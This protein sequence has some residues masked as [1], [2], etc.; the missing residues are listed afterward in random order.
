MHNV[1][2]AVKMPTLTHILTDIHGLFCGLNDTG[3]KQTGLRGRW[4]DGAV[5]VSCDQ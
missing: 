4:G 5:V 1:R 3:A 2:A